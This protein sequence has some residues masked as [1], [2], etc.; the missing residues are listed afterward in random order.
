MLFQFDAS[1]LVPRI[2]DS[3]MLDRHP[4]RTHGPRRRQRESWATDSEVVFDVCIPIS[5]TSKRVYRAA[6]AQ[7]RVTM[8]HL[9]S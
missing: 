4:S 9:V 5:M 3:Q 6:E 8:R 7:Y 2:G 1:G